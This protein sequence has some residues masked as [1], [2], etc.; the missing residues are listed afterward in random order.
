VAVL[1]IV[2]LASVVVISLAI[3]DLYHRQRDTNVQVCA[4]TDY[5]WQQI[6]ALYLKTGHTL[7]H[8]PPLCVL[9]R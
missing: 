4:V 3:G 7:P 9:P 2:G 1:V 6:K 8:P 5:Q